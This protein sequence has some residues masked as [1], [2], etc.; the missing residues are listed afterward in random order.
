MTKKI[1]KAL[2]AIS[3][4]VAI[5]GAI[6]YYLPQPQQQQEEID[7]H[8]LP[9]DDARDTQELLAMFEKDRYWLSANENFYPEFLL[10]N[11][12]PNK[13]DTRYYGKLSIKV[14]YDDAKQLVGFIAYYMK[15]F[16]MGQILFVDVKEEFRGKG[17]AQQLVKYA[18]RDLK[19][20]GASLVTLVTRTTNEAAQRVYKKLGFAISYEEEGYVYFEIRV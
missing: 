11:R 12:T 2:L 5:G 17:Y 20:Q 8:I 18:L 4:L 15:N 14:L 3:I 9:F 6:Y 1:I 19:R 13:D 10:K 16:F 7:Q